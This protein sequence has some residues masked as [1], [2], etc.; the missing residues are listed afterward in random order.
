MKPIAILIAATVALSAPQA[1]AQAII[2][3]ID[4]TGDGAGNVLLK[5]VGVSVHP[6]G[7]VYLTGYESHNAFEIVLGVGGG[8]TQII[9][10]TGDGAGNMLSQ[11]FD[12]AVGDDGTVY[13]TGS[14]SDNAFSVT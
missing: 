13:V 12:I 10:S 8:I 11:A 3:I 5:P 9:D 1:V 7:T 6:S 4:S 2:E 14:G